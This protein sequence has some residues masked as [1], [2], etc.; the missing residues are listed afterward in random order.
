MQHRV[1]NISVYL[2][3][4]ASALV[5]G[6]KFQLTEI[7]RMWLK[8]KSISALSEF[9]SDAKFSTIE[10]AIEHLNKHGNWSPDLRNA[11]TEKK[12]AIIGNLLLFFSLVLFILGGCSYTMKI[13]DGQTAYERKQYAK[14]ISLLPRGIKRVE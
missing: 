12:R 4:I 9:L 3:L 5:L 6:S 10:K 1:V 11:S 13:R 8:E 2:I 7:S 14:A